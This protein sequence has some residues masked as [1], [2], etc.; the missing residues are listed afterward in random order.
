MEL[1]VFDMNGRK[2]ENLVNGFRSAGY[3]S[4]TWAAS[5]FSSGIYFY[6]LKAGD[7]VETKKMVLMK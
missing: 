1:S 3:H 6:R 7:Y 2:V 4:V 5:G